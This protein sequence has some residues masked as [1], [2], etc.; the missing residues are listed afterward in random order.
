M[1]AAEV[2]LS[3]RTILRKGERFR[4]RG[5]PVWHGSKGESI[6][7]GHRGLCVMVA[8]DEAQKTIIAT[9]GAGFVAIPI[10]EQASTSGLASVT[11]EP[12][13]VRRLRQKPVKIKRRRKKVGE[14]ERG[15]LMVKRKRV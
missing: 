8:F 11:W 4:V 10:G 1:T 2:R 6:R 7:L 5:G 3:P 13:R 9:C 14:V 12:Y 15:K